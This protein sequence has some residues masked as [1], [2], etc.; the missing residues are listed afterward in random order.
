MPNSLLDTPIEHLKG[1]GPERAK[2]LK[3]ELEII[4]YGD[5]LRWY[6]YRYVDRTRFYT[7]REISPDL[8]YIQLR[9]QILD[10]KIVGQKRGQRMT[11]RFTDGLGTL[12]LVW[13]QGWKWLQGKYLPGKE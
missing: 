10:V 11:A 6:P 12:E 7:T 3:S 2:L 4:T 8:P 1:V 13:F 9:G 5:L